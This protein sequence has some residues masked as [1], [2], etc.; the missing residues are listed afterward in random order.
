MPSQRVLA[1]SR[2]FVLMHE[3]ERV[4]VLCRTTGKQVPAGAHHG[5]PTCGVIAADESWFVT[6]G[7]GVQVF[8]FVDGIRDFCREPGSPFSISAM[9]LDDDGAV[10]IL[11]DPWS[12]KA[13]VWRLDPAAGALI[14]LRDGPDLRDVV[15]QEDVPY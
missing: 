12:D 15:F 9:R 3:Y 7:E 11:V 8:T 2:H 1:E 14:K 10:R 6:G 4:F 13:S 5:D